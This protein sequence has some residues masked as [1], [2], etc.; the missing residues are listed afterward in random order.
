MIVCD[1]NGARYDIRPDPDAPPCMRAIPLDPATSETREM[2][3]HLEGRYSFPAETNPYAG[4]LSRAD[5]ARAWAT[6]RAQQ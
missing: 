6:G 2:V 5:L 1:H 3:A 4:R